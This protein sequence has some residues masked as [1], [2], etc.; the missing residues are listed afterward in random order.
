MQDFSLIFVICG[1][2]ILSI[3][4]ALFSLW[5]QNKMGEVKRIKKELKKK[6]VVFYSDSSSS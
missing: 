6:K 5:R 1:I 2:A 3:L 4:L